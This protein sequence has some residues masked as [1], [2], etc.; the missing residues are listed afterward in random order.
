M[1]VPVS[2]SVWR[3]GSV[4]GLQ[5]NTFTLPLSDSVL[6]TPGQAPGT[7]VSYSWVSPHG[8]MHGYPVPSTDPGMECPDPYRVY[9]E[10]D[11]SVPI[12][13]RLVRV[14]AGPARAPC[15]AERIRGPTRLGTDW[16]PITWSVAHRSR[17]RGTWPALHEP[18]AVP[19]GSEGLSGSER[20]ERTGSQ[21]RG[22]W[23]TDHVVEAP[24]LTQCGLNNTRSP[25]L[26]RGTGRS[27]ASLDDIRVS[28]E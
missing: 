11:R 4:G 24:G 12:D 25:C 6:G 8:S 15:C 3:F 21:S 7:T 17:G 16:V 1:T 20:R 19:N 18:R 27:P 5:K 10:P 13:T 22:P 23:H 28:Y 26:G 2:C 9:T 14:T